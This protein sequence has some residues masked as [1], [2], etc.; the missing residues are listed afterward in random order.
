MPDIKLSWVWDKQ[1]DHA[2]F[3]SAFVDTQGGMT[4]SGLH[5]IHNL[6]APGI[7]LTIIV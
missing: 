6:F 7:G 4:T 2:H 5:P 3:R 1:L